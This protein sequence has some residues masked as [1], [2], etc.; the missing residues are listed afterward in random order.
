M[1]VNRTNDTG[2]PV[3]MS[4]NRSVERQTP[5]TDFGSRVRAGAEAVAGALAA[6][7]AAVAPFVPGGAILSAAASSMAGLSQLGSGAVAS[8]YSAMPGTGAGLNT[9]LGPAGVNVGN[10]LGAIGVNPGG[11]TSS[12]I[13]QSLTGM[14]AD[15][16]KMMEIQIAMQRENTV[17]S[18][19][20]N[21]LKVRHDTQKNSVGN[22]R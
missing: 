11:P 17:F 10:A 3:R 12:T 7:A 15:N 5:K 19:L 6:G 2:T 4:T 20:S 18:T 9:T 8:H 16:L 13:N 14:Q 22:I 21:I 1:V